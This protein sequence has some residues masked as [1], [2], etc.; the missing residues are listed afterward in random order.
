MHFPKKYTP[1][2]AAFSLEGGVFEQN[3]VQEQT[4]VPVQNLGGGGTVEVRLGRKMEGPTQALQSSPKCRRF[5]AS[6]GFERCRIIESPPTHQI[7]GN[8]FN[9]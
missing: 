6:L 8:E 2:G 9:P 7:Q 5:Q 4:G 1:R 3:T